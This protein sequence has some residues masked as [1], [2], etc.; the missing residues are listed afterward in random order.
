MSIVGPLQFSRRGQFSLCNFYF[1]VVRTQREI[2][3]YFMK[4]YVCRTVLL[5]VGGSVFFNRWSLS[6]ALVPGPVLDA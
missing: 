1:I 4:L 2:T 5:T 3:A 6:P